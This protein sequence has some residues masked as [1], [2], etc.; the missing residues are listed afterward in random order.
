MDRA[1]ITSFLH[2]R[3]CLPAERSREALRDQKPLKGSPTKQILFPSKSQVLNCVRS[4]EG[5]K[6]VGKESLLCAFPLRFTAKSLMVGLWI[7]LQSQAS[8]TSLSHGS[9]KLYTP[10]LLST[11]IRIHGVLLEKEM[12]VRDS[13]HFFP[14]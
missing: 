3:K 8:G 5:G 7:G 1:L 14:I 2:K 9:M 13:C 10:F 4:W 12:M 6:K 11:V